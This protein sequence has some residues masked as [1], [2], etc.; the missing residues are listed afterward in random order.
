ME[1]ILTPA[2]M[3]AYAVSDSSQIG[4]VRRAASA[5]AKTIGFDETRCGQVAVVATELATNLSAHAKGGEVFIR[6]LNARGIELLAVDRGPGMADVERARADGFSTAGTAGAGLGAIGRL[7]HTFDIQSDPNVGTVSLIRMLAESPPVPAK[8]GWETG[9]VSLPKRGETVSGDSAAVSQD[10]E[11]SVFVLADGLGHGPQAA[12]A[13]EPTVTVLREQSHL[14]PKQMMEAMHAALRSTRGAA[15]AVGEV[16][17]RSRTLRFCGIGNI[18]AAMHSNGSK[19]Q[20]LISHN[21]I[22][23]HTMGRVQEFS[24][25]FP[26]GAVLILHSDGLK[27]IRDIGAHPGIFTRDVSLIAG[28]LYR[29]NRRERDDATVVVLREPRSAMQ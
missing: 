5:L 13:S 16:D 8:V 26:A 1:I 14:S 27:T 22:V 2:A 25:P 10:D 9:L 24:Y 12:E 15:V 3:K 19:P 6:Q 7:A 18:A 20:H 4:E 11:R 23:G 29:D 21:G 28:V 17:W